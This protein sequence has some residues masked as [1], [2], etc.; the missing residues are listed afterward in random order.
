MFPEL[1]APVKV[2]DFFF[3]FS[4]PTSSVRQRRGERG[5]EESECQRMEKAAAPGGRRP[6]QDSQTDVSDVIKGSRVNAMEGEEV[7]P[8]SRSFHLFCETVPGSGRVF[9]RC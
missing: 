9:L 7:T 5:L 4:S 2:I 6:R 3:F 1:V 8:S